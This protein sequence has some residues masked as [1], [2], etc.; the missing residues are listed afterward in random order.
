LKNWRWYEGSATEADKEVM[1]G[2][3]ED[4]CGNV[5]IAN[6]AQEATS[7]GG[8]MNKRT[9]FPIVAATLG[10]LTI[11]TTQ[12]VWGGGGTYN[13]GT[14]DKLTLNVVFEYNEASFNPNATWEGVFTLMS[15]HLW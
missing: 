6:D 11:L 5:E 8:T 1:H 3:S 10:L 15:G 14:P 12:V 13:E 9:T 2:K 7:G 4:R